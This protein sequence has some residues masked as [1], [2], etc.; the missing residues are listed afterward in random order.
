MG[1]I[2]EK[3]RQMIENK[4]KINMNTKRGTTL[5][6]VVKATLITMPITLVIIG[7]LVSADEV[8]GNMF[9]RFDT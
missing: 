1:E 8:F 7:L 2:F 3:I 6:K 5:K 9:M 4:L